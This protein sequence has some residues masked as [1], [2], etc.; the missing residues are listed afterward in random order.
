MLVERNL[1][2]VNFTEIKCKIISE[3]SSDHNFMNIFDKIEILKLY[4]RIKCLDSIL[5]LKL[6]CHN[7]AWE[8]DKNTFVTCNLYI[9]NK[10]GVLNI[11]IKM[12]CPI[13]RWRYF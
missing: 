11:H 5:H 9:M 7:L 13:L 2:M 10:K 8:L 3:T 6:I 1:S 12:T 4:I